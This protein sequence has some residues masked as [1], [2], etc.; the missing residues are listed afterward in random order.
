MGARCFQSARLE[1][2]EDRF[3]SLEGKCD[4]IPSDATAKVEDLFEAGSS[5]SPRLV[6]SDVG[7]GGLFH[8]GSVGEKSLCAVDS[9]RRTPSRFYQRDRL[10]DRF[11][12]GVFPQPEDRRGGE[13]GD[14][15]ARIDQSAPFRRAGPR[16]RRG[17]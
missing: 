6:S 9:S 10:L 14:F 7:G 1:V 16:P 17:F 13:L 12:I 3:D 11:S 5:E 2:D 8:C 4:R 15:C